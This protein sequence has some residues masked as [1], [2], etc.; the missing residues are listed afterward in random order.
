MES[1]ETVQLRSVALCI[2][3]LSRGGAERVMVNLAGRFAR[4]GIRVTLITTFRERD[5]YPVPEGV[6]RV[7]SGLTPDEEG[8]RL[9]NIYRR[10]VKL[11][12]IL[13]DA[14]PDLVLSFIG[15]T[16]FMAILAARPLHI[17]VAVS[18]RADPAMEYPTAGPRLLAELLFR[19]A[20]CVILQTAAQMDFFSQGIGRRS[21]VL[22][23]ALRS[24]FLERA[25]CPLSERKPLI[26]SVGRLDANKD[27]ALL[28]RAF[29]AARTRC[30]DLRERGYRLLILGE[31]DERAALE[32]LAAGLAIESLVDMPGSVPDVAERIGR[33][34][35][36]TLTSYQEGMPNALLEAMS[37]GLA[38][39]STDCPC[40]GPAE[41]I[42]D[43]EN[44]LLLAMPEGETRVGTP[45]PGLEEA[46]CAAIIRLVTD[47]PL[48]A[49][50]MEN[51]V[52]VRQ[53]YA[54]DAV[55]DKW[56]GALSAVAQRN[57]RS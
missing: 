25:I 17:P 31:G 54:P 10:I 47:R 7:I 18:V 52:H 42:H 57:V 22:P 6:T 35:I 43:G 38:C 12:C 20:E 44:G 5:E 13:S 33:A 32:E 29:A 4:D 21:I 39:I 53:E 11:R 37:L 23:N 8:A 30:E 9:S 16:N 34:E 41:L 15:K 36:F 48:M 2:G 14:A 40:G 19:Q 27:H 3:S 26:V 55:Y 24:E 46:L 1:V 50:I 56:R 51:A 45:Q 28:L 49:R